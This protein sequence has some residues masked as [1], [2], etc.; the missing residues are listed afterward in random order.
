MDYEFKA[1]LWEYEGQ[2]AWVF[3][4]LPKPIGKEIKE[5]FGHG[6]KGFGSI[7]VKAQIGTTKWRTSIFPD[8]GLASYVLPLK[9]EVRYAETLNIGDTAYIAL[10]LDV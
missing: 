9:K 6:R 1:K 10:S 7:R 8:N 2:G 5:L 4:T 3:V